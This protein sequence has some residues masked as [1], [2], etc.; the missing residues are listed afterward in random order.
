V[1]EEIIHFCDMRFANKIAL[2]IICKI[3][4]TMKKHLFL[5]IAAATMVAF[6]GCDKNENVAT[7]PLIASTQTWTFGDQ[8][9][10]DAIQ[11]PECNK[12]T[13]EDSYT[14]PQYRSYTEDG[15]TWY[16]YNWAYVDANREEM[17]PSPW[18]VPTKEDFDVLVSNTTHSVLISTWGYG[19]GTSGW[20]NG[21]VGTGSF[22]HYWSSTDSGIGACSLHYDSYDLDVGNYD[23][24]LGFQ[25]RCVK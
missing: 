21:A 7:P 12:E 20:L 2:F 1:G 4:D 16:Y 17:C 14:N 5:M 10:S 3:R 15:K 23:Y 13:F 22:A 9:W 11:C 19:G 24:Y 25:V 6:V 8:T 18:R